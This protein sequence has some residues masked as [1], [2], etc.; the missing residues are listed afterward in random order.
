MNRTA[1]LPLEPLCR[2]TRVR[3]DEPGQA[4]KLRRQVLSYPRARG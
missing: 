3:G 2:V 4:L 1:N